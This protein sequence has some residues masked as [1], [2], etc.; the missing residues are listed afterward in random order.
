MCQHQHL[1]LAVVLHAR[2]QKTPTLMTL[3]PHQHVSRAS[4][5]SHARVVNHVRVVHPA[6]S[7]K[8]APRRNHQ[9]QPCMSALMVNRLPSGKSNWHSTKVAWAS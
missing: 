6:E 5:A 4:H 2:R 1:P 7:V 3:M 9:S 8:I